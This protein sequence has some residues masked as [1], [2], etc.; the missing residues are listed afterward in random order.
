M[1]RKRTLSNVGEGSCSTFPGEPPTLRKLINSFLG[2]EHE[3]FSRALS[4][5]TLIKLLLDSHE[6]SKDA[7]ALRDSHEGSKGVCACQYSQSTYQMYLNSRSSTRPCFNVHDKN[8]VLPRSVFLANK[9]QKQP[10]PRSG[11]SKSI[12]DRGHQELIVGF[13]LKTLPT[14]TQSASIP[15]QHTGD[16]KSKTRLARVRKRLPA[17]QRARIRPPRVSGPVLLP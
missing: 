1:A 9:S 3:W 17:R 10:N 6:G 2:S 8:C 5:V 13:V 7:G 14:V 4:S 12:N 15:S 16:S 11:H